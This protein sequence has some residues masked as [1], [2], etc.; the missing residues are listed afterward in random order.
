MILTILSIQI[1]KTKKETK[2]RI[3][4]Y[5]FIRYIRITG[6]KFFF[7]FSFGVLESTRFEIQ[8]HKTDYDNDILCRINVS[9]KETRGVEQDVHEGSS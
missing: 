6:I 2:T 3:Q 4:K 8:V 9:R 7:S 5:I 1:S